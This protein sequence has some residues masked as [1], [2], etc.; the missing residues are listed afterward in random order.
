MLATRNRTARSYGSEEEGRQG[1]G[2]PWQRARR[3]APTS[4]QR[5]VEDAQL[6][7]DLRDAFESA[8]KAYG[9]MANGKSPAKALMDDKKTQRELKDAASSLND[10]AEALRGKKKKAPPPSGVA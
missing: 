1:R 2:R 3:P 4:V 8:R 6:R 5:L 10:A 9:R 7:E